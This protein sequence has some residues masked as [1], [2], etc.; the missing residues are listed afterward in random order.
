MAPENKGESLNRDIQRT[1]L[2]LK[3]IAQKLVHD[4]NN[5]YGAIQGYVSLLEMSPGSH[6]PLEKY[7]PAMH[8]AIRSGIERNKSIA[9]F[10]REAELMVI[11]VD[12][13]QTIREEVAGYASDKGYEVTVR[14][15]DDLPPLPLDEPKFREMIAKL[16]F[17]AEQTGTETPQ[18]DLNCIDLS[19]DD[20]DSLVMEGNAGSY[21]CLGLR[22]KAADVNGDATRFLEPF[23][24][25]PTPNDDL[26]VAM[27]LPGV[28]SHGGNLDLRR[29]GDSLNLS[30]YFPY[31]A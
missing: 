17:L 11:N 16:C 25:S 3:S 7:L 31:P 12:P 27:L 8:E 5:I 29:E 21:L 14:A 4:T 30:L 1:W 19:E 22:F 13:L 20:I 24:M 15:S 28:A 26:G 18:F 2:A 23:R 9:A 6:E 10:Y